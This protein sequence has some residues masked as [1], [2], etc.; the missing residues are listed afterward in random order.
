MKGLLHFF[1]PTL[2][3]LLV[4]G[5]QARAGLI[6]GNVNWDYN[7]EPST[8]AVFSDNGTGGITLSDPDA[9]PATNSSSTVATNLHVVSSADPDHVE[10][11]GKHGAVTLTLTIT[12]D[13]SKKTGTFVFTGKIGGFFS[14]G[15]S[16]VTWTNTGKTTESLTIGKHTYT[17][18]FYSYS[19]PSPTQ[20]I[21][22]GSITYRVDVGN[23]STGGVGNPEPASLVLAL[24]GASFVGGPLWRRRTGGVGRGVEA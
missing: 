6:K 14:S 22:K 16:N 18:S 13:A 2:A 7:W 24:L 3:A 19:P 11:L 5:G 12:D 23:A 21:N 1:L 8:K 4:A 10:L 20:A 9:A 15:Q 17:V